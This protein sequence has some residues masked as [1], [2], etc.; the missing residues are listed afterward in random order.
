MKIRI[1]ENEPWLES[2]N[3]G[4]GGMCMIKP[5]EVFSIVQDNQPIDGCTVSR[6]ILSNGQDAAI[7]FSMAKGTD[8]S[9]ETYRQNKLLWVLEGDLIVYSSAF[10][11]AVAHAGDAVWTPK[12]VPV[13]TRTETGA[14]YVEIAPEGVE[15]MSNIVPGEVFKLADLVPYQKG[16][17]VN[18]DV[19]VAPGMK[20]VVMA[21]DEGTGLS[22]HAAPGNAMVFGL[23]GEAV[24]NYEGVDH[25]LHAGEEIMFAKN[26]KHS[27]TAT[28]RFKMALLITLEK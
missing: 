19:L 12:D 18:R 5:G 28:G 21:F 20:F 25:V 17:I 24:V 23:E 26:G 9:A 27:V 22:E 13:G 8:I 14:I 11:Q 2:S 6:E 4:N 7:V 16:S 10:G 1:L 15:D 3:I